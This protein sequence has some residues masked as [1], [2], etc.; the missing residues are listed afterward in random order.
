MN[1]ENSYL[2]C[3]KQDVDNI[4]LEDE[5]FSYYGT[6]KIRLKEP[7]SQHDTAF[8]SN[9]PKHYPE[10]R[11]M[12]YYLCNVCGWFVCNPKRDKFEKGSL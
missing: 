9:D 1:V 6:I 12:D 7:C 2:P 8:P 11:Y 4:P 5:E 10:I 3:D